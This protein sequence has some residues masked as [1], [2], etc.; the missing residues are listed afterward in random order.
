MNGDR[1][2]A[3]A[4][5]H[6]VTLGDPGS[7]YRSSHETHEVNMKKIAIGCAGIALVAAVGIVCVAV[8]LARELPVLDASLSAPSTV[9]VD[10]TLT[11][12]VTAT[13]NHT[14]AI[15]LDS[16]DI[17][18]S[19][20]DGFQVIE[21]N[22]EPADTTHIFGMR[23]WDFGSAVPPGDSQVIHF[24]MKAIQEGHFS[25]DVDVCNPNQDFTTV[26]ADVVVRNEPPGE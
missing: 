18:D 16:I 20:L 17:Q 12:V 19:F 13:N 23:S 5:G 4:D 21:V 25:G 2:G 26:I 11:L 9:Q 3:S 15:V 7:G 8:W 1:H 14:Q 22:P 6:H 10:S 24:T